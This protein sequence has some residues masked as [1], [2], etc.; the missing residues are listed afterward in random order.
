MGGVYTLG[1]SPGTTVSNNVIHDVY[2]Y[3]YGGWGLYTDEGSSDI[4]M[5]NNLVYNVKSAGFHQHY[6]RDNVIRNN[7]FAFG[8]ENQLQRSRFEKHLSFTFSHNIVY[9]NEGS[10]LCGEWKD[11]KMKLE[12]NRY[13]DASGAPVKF[14]G[15][16]LTA[17]QASGKDAGSLVADPKFV[18]AAHFDFHLRPD[19]PAAKIGF[20]PFDFSKAGV[21]G[22]Q[23]WISEGASIVYPAVRLAPEPSR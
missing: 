21:Y 15:L 3:D 7:I 22:D 6:G 17:W 8:R 2:S 23:N 4:V 14:E 18:D 5:E 1:I 11:G 13:Y 10:L 16:D 9:W 20:Q 19:S 12:D